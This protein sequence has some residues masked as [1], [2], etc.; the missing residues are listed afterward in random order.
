MKKF[1]NKK[2][3]GISS[4]LIIFIAIVILI[5]SNSSYAVGNGCTRISEFADFRT[6]IINTAYTY[7][8]HGADFHYD[9]E[10][11]TLFRD[12]YTGNTSSLYYPNFRMRRSTY[13]NKPEEG[14][15]YERKYLVCGE[16]VN[17]T[18]YNTFSD[19]SGNGFLIHDGTKIAW[20]VADMINLADGDSTNGY[21]DSDGIKIYYRDITGTANQ[22]ILTDIKNK[23]RGKD[24]NG[25]T[26]EGALTLHPGD[27]IAYTHGDSGAHVML[28]VGRDF[29]REISDARYV[30][31]STG[32]TYNYDDKRD[33]TDTDGT[34]QLMTLDY[35]L[36]TKM[37]MDNYLE[38]DHINKVAVL[39]PWLS[40]K[41]NYCIS[42]DS[43]KR[44]EK[45]GLV[46][47]KTASVKKHESVNPG[48]KI[49][50]TITLAN[51]SSSTL[52][53]IN[54]S[55]TIP[56]N[57]E[58]VSCTKQCNYNSSTG[59]VT[60]DNIEVAHAKK[61]NDVM[62]VEN[63][64]TS[65]ATTSLGGKK[66]RN[67]LNNDVSYSYT[68]KVKD[69]TILGTK[70]VSDN[71]YVDGIKLSRIET[72]VNNTLTEEQRN[73]IITK[74][75]N[76]FSSCDDCSTTEKF[77]N[78]VY[79][80]IYNNN[81][82]HFF[83][84]T[85]RIFAQ[86]YFSK[87]YQHIKLNGSIGKNYYLFDSSGIGRYANMYVEGLFGGHE[88]LNNSIVLTS[89]NKIT[90]LKTEPLVPTVFDDR[91]LTYDK[92]TFMVGDVLALRD[93]NYASDEEC[94]NESYNGETS[95]TCSESSYVAEGNADSLYLYVGD[96]KFAIV[97]TDGK[98]KTL[99]HE[100]TYK[101][102]N[103]IKSAGRSRLIDSLMGQDAFVVLRPSQAIKT[104]IKLDV[105]SNDD[106]STYS[107]SKTFNI[108]IFDNDGYLSPGTYNI[109][110]K[111]GYSGSNYTCDSLT[112]ST[113]I[114][115]GSGVSS[116]ESASIT[117]NSGNYTRLFMCNVEAITGSGNSI[118]ANTFAEKNVKVDAKKPTL[119]LAT[120]SED[121]EV[122]DAN[123]YAKSQT[124]KFKL[125]DGYSGLKSGTYKIYY[126]TY[127]EGETVPV[128]SDMTNYKS[129]TVTTNNVTDKVY[130]IATT[131]NSDNYD[132]IAFCSKSDISDSVGNKI[133]ANEIVTRNLKVDNANPKSAIVDDNRTNYAKSQT[134]QFKLTDTNGSGLKQ[135]EYTIKYKVYLTKDDT[136]ICNDMTNSVNVVVASDG[137]ESAISEPVTITNG[138]YKYIAWC[139]DTAVSDVAGNTR[140]S[141]SIYS[142]DATF[143]VDSIS[144]K[145]GIVDDNRR[146]YATS[147]T[148]Q[149]KLTDTDGSGLKAGTYV[150]KYKVYAKNDAKPTCADMTDSVTVNVASDGLEEALSNSIT[151]SNGDYEYIGWC[152]DTAVS[153][154]AGNTR[155]IGN[156][157]SVDTI[158][159]VSNSAPSITNY[160]LK[161]NFIEG[162]NPKT[163]ISNFN[164]GIDNRYIVKILDREDNIKTSGYVGT[165][166][167]VQIY[168]NEDIIAEYITIVKG[169]ITGDGD[170]TISDVAKLY[171]GLKNKITL[172]D[173]EMEA[174]N[175]ID[176]NIIKINDVSKLYRYVKGKINTL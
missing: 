6:S 66:P 166:Y 3:I 90:G 34:V 135:G 142:K 79:Y 71:T 93:T 63:V 137:M 145:S 1:T 151:I 126:K 9:D 158:F 129:I 70:I 45:P 51:A 100:L 42:D 20:A 43:Q 35:A 81:T 120:K 23:I 80:S 138:N 91:E 107:D 8:F 133:T 60:W 99:D 109:K 105:I 88:T 119:D 65:N 15:S 123:I 146:N 159:R 157:Y 164:L 115:V 149:L 148:F 36:G 163:D 62:V 162:V 122:T 85:E 54:I 84:G 101:S 14:T 56:D 48:S 124:F 47:S 116:A 175:I 53:G 104:D 67:A 170:I 44:N 113:T 76:I 167:K 74:Y 30:L 169:D 152:N 72:V 165:G 32:N 154:V 130:S 125:Y 41:N 144:P 83:S 172:E 89:S 46:R 21:A 140:E 87:Q 143:K 118:A 19:S 5:I 22:A 147:Q 61:E 134:F 86:D 59:K 153:D 4:V 78:E 94:V 131:I 38:E 160:T 114:N 73:Y 141:G 55:D 26:V 31:H 161:G 174:G 11:I 139:N 77:I 69:N 25:N 110:Y 128:C 108:R 82:I 121:D 75:E 12:D 92:N 96:G 132:Y 103:I 150:L 64:I 37:K 98:L 127:A 106:L 97:G 68:I 17:S 136:P 27:I 2:I 40:I 57:T 112:N 13:A 10:K 28:Y 18:F 117:I 95:T 7:Y 52:T 50:Y 33:Y 111:F 29:N 176:D 39:R 173:Y 102:D 58:F 24:D 155:G 49:T 171:R 168:L 16:F 156:I